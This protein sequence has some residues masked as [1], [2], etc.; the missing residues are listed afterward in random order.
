MKRKILS[1][2]LMVILVIGLTGC[3]TKEGKNNG[4]DNK[5]QSNTNKE[6]N[7]LVGKISENNYGDAINYSANGID[8]WKIF[9][10]D[11]ENIFII[12]SNLIPNSMVVD[13]TGIERNAKYLGRYNVIWD[14]D[15]PEFKKY[16][17]V[18][19]IDKN[20]A[21]K[22][23]LSWIEKYPN[24]TDHKNMKV[25]ASLFDQNNWASF[26]D[27]NYADSAIGSPTLEMFINSWNAKHPDSKVYFGMGD[28]NG[29]SV[30]KEENPTD[31]GVYSVKGLKEDKLYNIV[32]E[33]FGDDGMGMILASP[34]QRGTDR[35]GG[36]TDTSI[37]LSD[38]FGDYKGVR[39]IVCLKAN[40]NA[41]YKNGVW[42]LESVKETNNNSES[43]EPPTS[44]KL[45]NDTLKYGKY[46]GESA[47][48][49]K[50]LILNP[51]NTAV[52]DGKTY[53]FSVEKYNFAQD[54]SSDSY[55]DAI[56][57]K[58]DDGSIN[59]AFYFLNGKLRDDPMAYVYD[60]D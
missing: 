36:A 9:Y 34:N 16:A 33:K 59:S 52:L 30:G 11:G 25:V 47:A 4:E 43:N 19:S 46:K 44:F 10:N 53:K 13:G 48:T 20:L 24:D 26:V 50:T 2:L 56:V 5:N 37:G 51:D 55:K 54:S 21:K 6:S 18:S 14:W 23:E 40:V 7:T 39:P 38:P 57:L 32:P 45:G 41:T 60:G 22:Y 15:N 35:V 31:N 58:N 1:L 49:G 17:G 12:T 27:N 42:E 8:D 3:G 28:E 29:Y